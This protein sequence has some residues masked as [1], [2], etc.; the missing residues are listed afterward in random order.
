MALHSTSV[1]YTSILQCY[2]R[3][4]GGGGGGGIGIG[5]EEG[6]GRGG[7]GGG[8][9]RDEGKRRGC[10][11]RIGGGGGREPER[12]EEGADLVAKPVTSSAVFD[13]LSPATSRT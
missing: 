6:R 10:P 12:A 11:R 1:N 5:L 8:R 2:T 9:E 7:G 13:S 4:G 3:R